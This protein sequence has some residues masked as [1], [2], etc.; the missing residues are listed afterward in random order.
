VDVAGGI[1][2]S[3]ALRLQGANTSVGAN[4]AQVS[5][6]N[7]A[8]A[9]PTL[10]LNNSFDGTP[11]I[12]ITSTSIQLNKLVTGYLT[13]TTPAQTPLLDNNQAGIP[14]S[15]YGSLGAGL[16]T[17]LA[18]TAIQG[19]TGQPG[20][21]VSAQGYMSSVTQKWIGGCGFG[22]ALAPP[23]NNFFIQPNSTF[24]GLVYGNVAGFNMNTTYTITFIRLTGDLGL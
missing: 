22:Q 8:T 14:S 3:I 7:N 16:F 18:R 1:P 11:A 5:T 24:T 15:D 9:N 19:P 13:L 10:N 2:A 23:T 6:N 17:I 20:T 4:T 12:Q 21:Q